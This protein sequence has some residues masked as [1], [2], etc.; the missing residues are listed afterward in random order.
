MLRKQEIR[1]EHKKKKET[2][3]R[4]KAKILLFKH[5]KPG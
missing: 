2:F 5:M 1:K 4:S 3:S